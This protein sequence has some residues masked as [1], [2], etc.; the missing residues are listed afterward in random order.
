VTDISEALLQV[1]A[2]TDSLSFIAEVTDQ[3]Y[4][5]LSG[6]FFSLKPEQRKQCR[7]KRRARKVKLQ[8]K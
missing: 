5:G 3:G 6:P 4:C 7:D 1:I 8:D 2:A